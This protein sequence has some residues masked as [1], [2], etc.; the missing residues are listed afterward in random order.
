MDLSSEYSPAARFLAEVSHEVRS[1][2]HA[3]IGFAELLEDETFGA[4]NPEQLT[5]VEDIRC[6]AKHLLQVLSDV[7]DISRAGMD[8]LHLQP[9]VLSLAAVVERAVHMARGLAGNKQVR[10]QADIP[11]DLAV[12]GDEC[13]VL[14]VLHNLL[15]NAI[16]CSPPDGE[17]RV[18]AET[19]DA[20]VWTVVRDHGCGIDPADHG[21][22][23]EPFVAIQHGAEEPGVGLGLSVSRNLAE[24]M[25][26]T[27][28]VDSQPGEGATFRFSLPRA[29]RPE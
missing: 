2:L 26:G 24:A 27:I 28:E 21:R 3:I 29:E 14:Q 9:E 20:L 17:V 12:R 16:R 18:E 5:A 15:A 7:L 10:L 22:I 4:L 23:F 19:T 8:R 25:G 1:P 6:A 13:R 11:P